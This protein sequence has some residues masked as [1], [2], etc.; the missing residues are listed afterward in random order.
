[1]TTLTSVNSLKVS[2]A[3]AE[4]QVQR[5]QAQVEDDRSQLVQSQAQLEKDQRAL[6]SVQAQSQR[7]GQAAI[8]A[9]P[10]LNRAIQSQPAKPAPQPAD[11]SLPKASVNAQGQAIGTLINV[12]A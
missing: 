11:A 3:L 8:S 1:M 5:D 12:L 7:A 9:P 4:R 10:E 2:I 6:N